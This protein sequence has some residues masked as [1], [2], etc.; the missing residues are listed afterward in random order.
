MGFW[1][2]LKIGHQ[3]LRVTMPLQYPVLSLGGGRVGK[4]QGLLMVVSS[5]CLA[6]LWLPIYLFMGLWDING[7]RCLCLGRGRPAGKL[8]SLLTVKVLTC[9]FYR[10]L[11]LIREWHFN[12]M[13]STYLIC[14]IIFYF[15]SFLVKEEM[16]SITLHIILRSVSKIKN[17]KDFDL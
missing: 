14:L 17:K 13:V 2:P 7:W 12:W 15:L 6:V 1:G 9:T 16:K 5:H 10:F 3:G 8:G 11:I 4:G